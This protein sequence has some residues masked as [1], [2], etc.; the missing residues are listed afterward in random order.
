MIEKWSFRLSEEAQRSNSCCICFQRLNSR[1]KRLTS[2]KTDVV[3]CHYQ[4][5]YQN[6]RS[7][8]ADAAVQNLPMLVEQTHS[9]NPQVHHSHKQPHSQSDDQKPQFRQYST[10]ILINCFSYRRM[11]TFIKT[12]RL[13]I[14]CFLQS[15]PCCIQMQDRQSSVSR[16]SRSQQRM[17]NSCNKLKREDPQRKTNTDSAARIKSR[18]IWSFDYLKFSDIKWDIRMTSENVANLKIESQLTLTEWE[19]LMTVLF[20]QKVHCHDISVISK[21]YDQKLCCLRRFRQYH[22]RHDRFLNF[23]YQEH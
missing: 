6:S 5:E 17:F 15:G 12:M 13:R 22:I 1:R 14:W 4:S 16:S 19:I 9:L 18:F 8:V 23:K 11:C 7:R 20:N 10:Y 2:N 3:S 21:D